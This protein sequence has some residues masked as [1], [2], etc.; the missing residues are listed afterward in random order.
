MAKNEETKE[1]TKFK[2]KFFQLGAVLILTKSQKNLAEIV[3]KRIKM[4]EKSHKPFSKIDLTR[5][6][7]LTCGYFDKALFSRVDT[8]DEEDYFSQQNKHFS[9][10]NEEQ[11]TDASISLWFI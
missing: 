4:F 6:A 7:S 9:I 3:L 10:L 11:Q 5:Y 8:T 2:M 1:T